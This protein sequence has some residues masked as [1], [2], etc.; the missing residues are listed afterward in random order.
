M[1]LQR[2]TGETGD[3]LEC[4]RIG[5]QGVGDGGACMEAWHA[6]RFGGEVARKV[7]QGVE[8]GGVGA[9][10]AFVQWRVDARAEDFGEANGGEAE[11]AGGEWVG[12]QG[13]GEVGAE[14]RAA[15]GS[16]AGEVDQ[17]GAGEVAQADLTGQGREQGAVGSELGGMLGTAVRREAGEIDV[18]C[19][20]RGGWLD[21]EAGA[22]GKRGDRLAQRLDGGF[23]GIIKGAFHDP[24][25]KGEP[26][27]G[28]WIVD[29]DGCVRVAGVQTG[30]GVGALGE[31]GGWTSAD[32]ELLGLGEACGEARP[33]AALRGAG[34]AHAEDGAS[35][36]R[37]LA[38]GQE[39]FRAVDRHKT[40][41]HGGDAG[42]HPAAMHLAHAVRRTWAGDG[43]VLQR[44]VPRRHPHLAGGDAGEQPHGSL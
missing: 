18:Q 4:L 32:Q 27:G 29:V 38:V 42:D 20:Q 15:F 2:T 19:G 37:P 6:M 40:A 25:G 23:N 34:D 13:L 24:G 17:D 5:A 33:F 21:R 30:E 41:G 31:T 12:G 39:A 10:E 3:G 44:A 1:K 26:G 9:G 11:E 35:I 28:A 36:G 7:A 14:G 16:K 43:V 8:S 22:A